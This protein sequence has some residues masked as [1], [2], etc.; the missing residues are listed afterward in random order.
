[1]SKSMH[2]GTEA[3][4]ETGSKAAVA[5][6]SSI[7]CVQCAFSEVRSR[8]RSMQDCR[9]RSGMA[10]NYCSSAVQ[11]ALSASVFLRPSKRG[12][13]AHAASRKNS[14]SAPQ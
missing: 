9:R 11:H 13:N 1:M 14:E 2:T 8:N 3:R 4:A 6:L 12:E 10:V 7:V 5:K